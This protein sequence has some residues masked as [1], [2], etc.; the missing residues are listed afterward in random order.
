LII[1]EVT[2]RSV[3]TSHLLVRQQNFVQICVNLD[4]FVSE[5]GQPTSSASHG[6]GNH[7]RDINKR[8]AHSLGRRD[9]G[10]SVE[11]FRPMVLAIGWICSW[12]K[13]AKLVDLSV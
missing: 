9:T 11:F 4:G 12:G 5:I 10:D 2:L 6:I 1:V 13:H 8:D 7:W 3:K